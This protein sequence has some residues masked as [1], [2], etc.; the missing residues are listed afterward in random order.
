[1]N[2]FFILIFFLVFGFRYEVGVDWFNYI[3]VYNR[4]VR[5]EK[6]FD[7]PELAYKAINLFAYYIG[8]G[9]VT[10]I[11]LSTLLFISFTIYGISRLKLNPYYFFALVSAYHFIMSGMNL[12]RQAIALSVMLMAFG[13]LLQK[14]KVWFVVLTIFAGMFH[15]SA[16]CFFPLIFIGSKLRYIILAILTMLPI[17]LY[18]ML[19]TY[20]L[21]LDGKLDNAGLYLRAVYI[22]PCA[23][24]LF[25]NYGKFMS[26]I[27]MKR[28]MLLVIF[29][30]PFIVILSNLSST[31][32]DRFSYYFILLGAFLVYYQFERMGGWKAKYLNRY[33]P[34]ILFTANM[35]ALVIWHFYS[36]YVPSYIFDSYLLHWYWN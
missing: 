5:S 33:G 29:S 15:T 32:A 4:H 13:F 3:E 14:R 10:T 21:Y 19:D 30:F 9:I 35:F 26:D 31:L 25:L 24:F 8:K 1:M 34:A 6:F 17:L 11:L 36:G 23:L 2:L 18:Q 16:L 12:T 20:S 7:T 28:L 27:I 22:L